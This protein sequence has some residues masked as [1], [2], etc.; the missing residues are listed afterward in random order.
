MISAEQ[1]QPRNTSKQIDQLRRR[2][3]AW[4]QSHRPRARIP[5]GLW[6]LAVKLAGRNGLNKTAKALRLDYYDLK[7]R[8]DAAA[9][10]SQGPGPS[11][12]ELNSPVLSSIPECLIEFE[13]RSGAKMKIHL[14]SMAM[15]DLS[16][17]SRIFSRFKR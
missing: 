4:R 13:A 6:N 11:F 5:E 12:I 1:S 16:T 14:K 3:D 17:V 15:P 2:L 10:V 9:V 7:K 8:L